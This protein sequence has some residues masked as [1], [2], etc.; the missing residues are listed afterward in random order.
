MSCRPNSH[1][2]I[3]FLILFFAPLTVF[4]ISGYLS[5]NQWDACDCVSFKSGTMRLYK[6]LS[7]CSCLRV[8]LDDQSALLILCVGVG[9]RV[10]ERERQSVREC[11]SIGT[12]GS[13][14][15]QVPAQ[16]L[17]GTDFNER[18]PMSVFHQPSCSLN[19]AKKRVINHF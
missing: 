14:A 6:T 11:V 5:Q 1:H 4:L 18:R 3:V 17:M 13:G 12:V 8:A 7:L 15:A 9:E 19:A 2:K 16:T 10:C